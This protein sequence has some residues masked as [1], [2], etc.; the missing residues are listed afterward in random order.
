MGYRLVVFWNIGENVFSK[1]DPLSD[2]E[3]SGRNFL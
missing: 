2:K 1:L 3:K